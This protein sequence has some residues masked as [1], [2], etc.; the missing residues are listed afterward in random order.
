MRNSRWTVTMTGLA[1]AAALAACS[2]DDPDKSAADPTPATES[3]TTATPTTGS[4]SPTHSW[5]LLSDG[6]EAVLAAGAYGLISGGSPVKSVA[7][8]RAPAGY[9]QH[10]GRIFTHPHDPT[11]FLGFF[12]AD[13]IFGDPCGTKGRRTKTQTLKNVGPTVEDLATALTEQKG[14]T[15]S[16]PV[17]ASLDG[18]DGL[19]LDYQIAKGVD[20]STCEETAF[21]IFTTAPGDDDSMWLANSGDR[22][23][24][25]ILDVEG[26][27]IV[28]FWIAEPGTTKAKIKELNAMAESTTF[29]PSDS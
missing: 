23:A 2:D 6:G 28:L 27:R 17:P 18:Y 26:D 5:T 3:S 12:T 14:A 7:V 25:W 4:P 8:V 20:V 13:R 21:D 22:V 29:E 19:Y 9:T 10:E 1:L 24:M 11:R 15:T 16:T